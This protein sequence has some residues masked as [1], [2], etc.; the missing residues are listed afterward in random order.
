M[1][2]FEGFNTQVLGISVDHLPCLH[3]WQESIGGISYPL[4]SDFWPHGSVAEKYGVM[5]EDGSSER[6]IFIVDAEGIIQYIDIH[7]IDN[8]PD[9]EEIFKI[10]RALNPD[11]E[12]ASTEEKLAL[13][14]GDII[15][16]CT[17][18]CPDC[19]K[20]RKWLADHKIDYVEIDID[21]YPEA[22]KNLRKITG[23]DLITP[24]FAIKEKYLI[25]FD[26]EKMEK[27]F[28]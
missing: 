21:K 1:A 5:R 19:K 24:T 28:L 3:A 13:P 14:T 27:M 20:A 7:D 10:L 6:A 4:C 22:S 8:Q 9:N 23:G 2:K 16:Y 12:E 11:L 26:E 25:D 18:W 17:S 15:M